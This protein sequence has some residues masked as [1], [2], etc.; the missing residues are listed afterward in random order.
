MP[1]ASDW[2][3]TSG[4]DEV[5]DTIGQRDQAARLCR[6]LA[7]V[8]RFQIGHARGVRQIG[9]LRALER[10]AEAFLRQHQI[11]LAQRHGIGTP[12]HDEADA[13]LALDTVEE[14]SAHQGRQR[15]AHA[16][17]VGDG[18]AGDETV[19]TGIE[20]AEIGF[21]TQGGGQIAKLRGT[22]PAVQPMAGGV[23]ARIAPHV[24]ACG[25]ERIRPRVP[26]PSRDVRG[27]QHGRVIDG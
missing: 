11:G 17:G 25:K 12:A 9:F 15:I 20:I 1:A 4:S 5:G 3:R 8:G 26:A 14:E 19:E 27:V 16:H 22:E 10:E 23:I 7:V 2:P 13:A 24:R 6:C 18:I 21:G